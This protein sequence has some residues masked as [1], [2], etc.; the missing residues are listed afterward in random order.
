[1]GEFMR[2]DLTTL[3][4]DP[5]ENSKTGRAG[6]TGTVGGA[7]S[8]ASAN[9]ETR[10]SFDHARVESL[11]AQAL[12]QSETRGAKVQALQRA[13]G[14]GEYSVSPSQVADALVADALGQQS[15]G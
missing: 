5:P 1:M 13:I 8:D 4:V 12:A 9:D 7:G 3:G 11:A 15:A 2:I 10:F 14:N 6:Q